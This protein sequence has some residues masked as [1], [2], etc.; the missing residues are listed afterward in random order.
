M[1]LV[2]ENSSEMD[3]TYRHLKACRAVTRKAHDKRYA[4][5]IMSGQGDV[6]P[7]KP[8]NI[9]SKVNILLYVHRS[10]VDY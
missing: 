5:K 8:P 1:V 9:L 10:E 2:N 6:S 7:A 4:D 3:E